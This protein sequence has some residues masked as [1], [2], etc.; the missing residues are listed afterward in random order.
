MKEKHTHTEQVL[1]YE[2]I[3]PKLVLVIAVD[4]M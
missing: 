2:T 1:N 3:H 4:S